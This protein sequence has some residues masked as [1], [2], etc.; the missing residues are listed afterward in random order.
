V[1]LCY[2]AKT[3]KPDSSQT[4]SRRKTL[5]GQEKMATGKKKNPTGNVLLSRIVRSYHSTVQM[6]MM[7]RKGK[8][9]KNAQNLKTPIMN[10]EHKR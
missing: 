8:P 3:N 7:R 4:H 6:L 10:K 9:D 5:S 1:I 2:T